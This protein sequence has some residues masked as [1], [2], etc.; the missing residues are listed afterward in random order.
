MMPMSRSDRRSW[1]GAALLAAS[2]G[3]GA[4]LVA[5]SPGDARPETGSASPPSSASRLVGANS[6]AARGCHG[7]VGPVA[8]LSGDVFIK[9]GAFTTWSQFDPHARAYEV[10]RDRRSVRIAKNL[11]KALGAEKAHEAK[12][13]LACH[14]TATSPETTG[15]GASVVDGVSCESCHGPA[16]AWLE[17]HLGQGWPKNLPGRR[18]QGNL[19]LSSAADRARACVDCHVGNRSRGMDVNHDLIAAGHPRL[20]FEYSAYL[21]NYPKHWRE[22]DRATGAGNSEALAWITGQ[23]VTARAS[24][25]LLAER[26]GD[27]M[28]G[29][30]SGPLKTAPWPELAE[31]ECFACHHGLEKPGWTPDR[32]PFAVKPGQP[33]W[34]TW[35]W[36]MLPEFKE[37]RPGW[38]IAAP[39]SP[40]SALRD[41]MSRPGPD[42]QRV[43]DRAGPVA[44]LI[45]QWLEQAKGLELDD[46]R[47]AK[48]AERLARGW[49]DRRETWDQS[50]QRYLAL[51]ALSRAAK[52]HGIEWPGSRPIAEALEAARK[53]LGF[54]PG[55][56]SP[57]GGRPGAAPGP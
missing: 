20:H 50:A 39:G 2:A 10:L 19:V 14:A 23:L 53:R 34:A 49:P 13:C 45:D 37:V 57:G 28:A 21:A 51:S 55:F 27:S 54:A 9:D 12:T 29:S 15:S 52:T 46:D 40:L 8:P 24:L 3:A 17:T 43:V 1:F 5:A 30:P 16:G 22:K 47:V 56:D 32:G 7:A 18:S 38:D 25:G 33:A 42:A 36:A 6:C 44:R 4:V 31:S 35:P 26:A 48:L 41:E 11:G